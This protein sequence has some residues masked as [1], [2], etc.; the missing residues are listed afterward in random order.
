MEK[1]STFVL[2]L[3]LAGACGAVGAQ[4]PTVNPMPDGS[5]DMYVGLGVVSAPAYEGAERRRVAALPVLQVEW[6]NG[7]FISGLKAGMHLSRD[8]AVE[9]GPL[10]AYQPR[11]SEAG[12]QDGIGDVAS[13]GG[14][15]S[16]LVAAPVGGQFPV[17]ALRRNDN[18][19]VGLD[20]IAARVLAG[21]FLNVYLTPAVRVT[22][23]LLYGSGNARSGATLTLGVQRL[24]LALAAH[25]TLSFSAGATLA[26]RGDSQA[27]FGVSDDGS[28]R[29][30]NPVYDAHAGLRTLQASA[31]WNWAL[32]PAW[33]LSTGVL[34][35]HLGGASADSPLVQR[36]NAATLSSALAL[37]F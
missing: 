8:G 2:A 20:D 33:T 31:R 27:Y 15:P 4:T 12:L 34:A 22:G 35:S 10:L 26:N 13:Q 29:S 18:R 7:M 30:G 3:V 19:L 17:V 5:R 32:A 23:E 16:N 21:A 36:V 6:S 11:R 24:A 25:H 14:G 28:I 1:L 9:F 37:R